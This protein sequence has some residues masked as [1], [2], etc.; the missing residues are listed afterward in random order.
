MKQSDPVLSDRKPDLQTKKPGNYENT[1]KK[2]PEG[3]GIIHHQ[4]DKV[5]Q[6]SKNQAPWSHYNASKLTAADAK[7]I[8]EK[9]REAGIH[10]WP[11]TRDAIIAAGF[12]PEKL[13]TLDPP[14]NPDNQGKPSP[15][16]DEE[17][18]KTLG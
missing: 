16:S 3:S 13:R 8:H 2:L 5:L 7:A 12:D 18:L 1:K 10:A 4:F 14:K 11:E 9:L 6:N 17:R 15:P